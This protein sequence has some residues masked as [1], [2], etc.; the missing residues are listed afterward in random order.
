MEPRRV[1][2]APLALGVALV[3]QLAAVDPALAAPGDLD[4]TFS[5][6]GIAIA[7]FGNY[8]AAMGVVVQ[9]NGRIVVSGNTYGGDMAL[10]RY[11]A[12]GTKDQS[13]GHHGKVRTPFGLAHLTLA[14]GASAIQADDKVVVVG[15]QNLQTVTSTDFVV[16]RY[17]KQGALDG[18]FGDDGMVVTDVSSN[19]DANDV[20][21][22]PDRKIV[23][24]GT[25]ITGGGNDANF[26][27]AR[28]LTNGDL[29]LKFD[30]DGI[31]VIDLGGYDHLEGLA[32][33]PDGKMILA[34]VT[35]GPDI[36]VARIRPRGA[37]DPT[38]GGGDGYVTLDLGGSEFANDVAVQPDGKIVVVGSSG[39]GLTVIRFLSDGTFDGDFG[40]SGIVIVPISGEY[41]KARAVDVQ[42]D[43]KIVTVG[44][45]SETELLLVRFL[46][47]G[48]RDTTFGTNGIVR[49]D[50]GDI[51]EIANAMAIQPDGAIVV[52]GDRGPGTDDDFLTCRYLGA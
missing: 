23:A 11:L 39:R 34:G 44:D 3:L 52:A 12:S 29:D 18:S 51:Y 43:G 42:P 35:S 33:Q 6:D 10:I 22:Q 15:G 40:S 28:Y 31:R 48:T 5:T 7:D 9:S 13:Y 2:L 19:D 41:P 25:E 20:A 37:L 32:L 24:A 36:L 45:V 1:P 27:V 47:D 16:L 50:L 46:D 38:F 26:E 30:G 49:T 17:T 4:T 14:S 8:D 21:I